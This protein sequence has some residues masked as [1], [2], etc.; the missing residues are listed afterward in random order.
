MEQHE[1]TI[2]LLGPEAFGK[3]QNSLVVVAGLGGV[4]GHCADAL[5]RAGVGSLH[6]ID[7]DT[8][9][10]TNL[11][12]QLAA[13]KHTLGWK[14]TDAMKERIFDVSDCAV[15]CSDAFITSE[16]VAFALPEN[17]DFI[18]DAIDTLSGKLALVSLALERGV[19]IVCSMGAG[20]RLDPSRF[21]VKDIYETSGD[22][23]ARRMRQEL[24]KR[25]VKALPV[26]VS[27]EPPHVEKGQTCIGSLAPVT[28]SAGLCLAGY[29]I[30]QLMK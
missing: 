4:G 29:V 28:A 13:G 26:V 24:R 3:L 21:S 20:N 27:D 30:R 6:L 15:T 23:L 12:R 5:A 22:P 25:G 7:S 1:R 14:K 10:I 8:V 2:R 9:N 19:P 18:V 17:V 16:T 11:N